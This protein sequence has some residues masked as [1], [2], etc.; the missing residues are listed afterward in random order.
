MKKTSTKPVFARL[1]TTYE[2]LAGLH[3]PRPIHDNIGYENTVEMIDALAGH[4]LNA[5]QEDYLM[6]LGGQIEAYEKKTASEEL[7]AS[8]TEVLKYL[9]EEHGLT[10]NDLAV[11]LDIDRSTAYR[12]LKAE[13]NLTTGHLKKLAVHFGVSPASFI[14]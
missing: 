9:L 3:M 10:G 7:E 11:I 14:S 12:I 6:I 8:G 2:G 1:P 5:D 4:N 13:R